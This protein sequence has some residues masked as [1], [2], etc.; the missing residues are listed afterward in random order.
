MKEHA[1]DRYNLI[2]ETQSADSS[3]SMPLGGHNLGCNVWVENS[4]L[5]LYFQQSG[6]F[7]EN[8]SMLKA[9]RIRISFSGNPFTDGFRQTLLLRDGRISIEGNSPSGTFHADLWAEVHHPAVHIELRSDYPLSVTASYESWRTEDRF[10]DN[11]SYELFQCKEVWGDPDKPVVFHKDRIEAVAPD[12]ML[13]CHRNLST[14][15]SFDREMDTQGLKEFKVNLYNP[16]VNRTTGGI[17]KAPGMHFDSLSEGRYVDTDFKAWNFR[18]PEAVTSQNIDLF[19]HT[20]QTDTQEIWQ[21]GLDEIIAATEKTPE[22]RTLA[23]EETRAWWHAYWEK[24]FIHIGTAEDGAP[25]TGATTP[26]AGGPHGTEPFADVSRNYQLFRYMLGCNYYG[27]WPTKFNG[28]LFTFDPI[29]AGDSPWSD[30]KLHYT[31]DYRLWG[32]GSHTTQNQRL[33]Y[34]PM[35]K[36]GDFDMMVQT[37]E[38]FRRLLPVSKTRAKLFFGVEGAVYPEQIGAYGLCATC[39]HGWGNTT[40]L[41]VPQI[42]YLFSN[43]LEI[44]LMILDWADYTGNDISAYMEFIEST[45][46]FYDGFYPENDERGKMVMYPANA[47]ETWHV[48]KNPIDAVAGLSCLLRRM[49]HR[50]ENYA[51]AERKARWAKI[52]DR[53]PPVAFREKNGHTIIAYADTESEIHNCEIPELYAVF[54]YDL[55]GLGKPGLQTAI[56]TARFAADTDEQNTHVSW[57][58]QGIHYA[59]LGMTDE[60]VAFLFKK[61]GNAVN[62]RTPVFWGPGHDWTPDHNWGGSGMIQLQE[63]LLQDDGDKIRLLPCWPKDTDVNFR[64]HARQNTVVDCV[65]KNGRI[66]ELSVIPE[67][68]RKDIQI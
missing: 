21:A 27:K 49:L 57:H 33:L 50:G 8:G 41:P 35:L 42:K 5:L 38:F 62:R 23:R 54:P 58:Q 7:D 2:W 15:L 24:S 16:Q 12:T 66:E 64:L 4:Q 45:V 39:D 11:G 26:P 10:V 13:F 34:W 65:Y 61:M 3:E 48:V 47:L 14:D 44:A 30:I 1:M 40:G 53:V 46:L 31:P 29:L 20:A 36:S 32:G 52:L 68:R 60:A 6:C 63:M 25:G 18:T 56:D 51:D 43:Q 19:L 37:F 17:M 67:S 55:F 59:R 9:G 28:G 22:T